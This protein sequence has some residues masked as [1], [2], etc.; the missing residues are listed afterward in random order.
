LGVQWT[1]TANGTNILM[2]ATMA[3]ENGPDGPGWYAR[4][5]N[6][7]QKLQLGRSDDC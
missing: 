4:T 6:S 1:H 5:G 3:Y 7:K 2:D